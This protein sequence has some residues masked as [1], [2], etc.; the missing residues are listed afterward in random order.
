MISLGK[1]PVLWADMVLQHPE[2]VTYLPEGTVLIDWNYG[3]D[4][5]RFGPLEDMIKNEKITFWGAAAIRSHPDNYFLTD[6]KRHLDNIFTYTTF[7]QKHFKGVFLTS[8]A[9][10]GVYD[11]VREPSNHVT[12]IVPLRRTFPDVSMEFMKSLFAKVARGHTD[13]NS[14]SLEMQNYFRVD[15][16]QASQIWESISSSQKRILGNGLQDK[17]KKTEEYLTS[18]KTHI[19]TLKNIKVKANSSNFQQLLLHLRMRANYLNQRRVNFIHE[20]TGI[21]EKLRVEI[22]EL[23]KDLLILNQEYL[24]LFRSDYHLESLKEDCATR[25]RSLQVLVQLAK[26]EK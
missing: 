21:D 9:T 10:S 7:S 3:W 26:L 13:E 11:Y 2:A 19:N 24:E 1:V 18:T 12:E 8:W 16:E 25:M 20:M 14:H 4:L 17:L 6:W 22:S 23:K 15:K 5:N